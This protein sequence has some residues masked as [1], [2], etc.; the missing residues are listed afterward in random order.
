MKASHPCPVNVQSICMASW[1]AGR[2]AEG[3]L[4]PSATITCWVKS[5]NQTLIKSCPKVHKITLLTPGM[6]LYCR[7]L[8]LTHLLWLKLY[9]HWSSTPHFL[10]TAILGLFFCG[11]CCCC[12]CCYFASINLAILPTSCTWNRAAFCALK[13]CVMLVHL[14]LTDLTTKKGGSKQKHTQKIKIRLLSW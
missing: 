7:S 5:K 11:F 13:N 3:F 9:A 4:P 1:V 2:H 10:A 6:R 8:E 14:L 12:C